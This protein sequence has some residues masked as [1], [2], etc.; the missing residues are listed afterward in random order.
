MIL[1]TILTTIVLYIPKFKSILLTI[2]EFFIATILGQGVS[3]EERLNFLKAFYKILPQN[4]ITG[5]GSG[6]YGPAATKYIPSLGSNITAIVNNVYLEIW[7]EFGLIPVLIFIGMLTY[8]ISK[9]LLYLIKLPKWQNNN[10]IARLI[11][12]F[13]LLAYSIQW[14]TFSPIFIMPIFIIIGL[15]TNLED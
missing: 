9:N 8:I 10:E 12:V 14:L 1:L 5:I 11:L 4:I 7:L 3:A 13:S 2:F 15:I 6:Q